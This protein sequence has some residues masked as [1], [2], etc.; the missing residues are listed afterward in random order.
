MERNCLYI[1]I[2]VNAN[3]KYVQNKVNVSENQV[4]SLIDAI[5]LRNAVYL[6]FPKGGIRGDHVLLFT[7]AQINR[8]GK[9]QVEGRRAYICTSARQVAKNVSYTGG[10]LG[11]LA[12]LAARALPT[13]L[14]GLTSGLPSG[15]INKA[16]SG[17]GLY[18]HKHG[19][20]Y[21]V[22][23][24]KCDDLYLAPHLRF[25]EG[26]GLF[27]KQG[28]D[29]SDGVGLLMGLLMGKNSPFKNIPVLWWCNCSL[30]VFRIYIT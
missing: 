14:T 30:D 21:R 4:D 9:A 13:I 18:L 5:R 10:F 3:S 16:I 11:M 2:F 26:D 22:Q 12:S 24:C 29:I 15:C 8:L 19:K 17:D 25:V 20:C 28:N 7:L 23:N 6:Y 27:L 1:F